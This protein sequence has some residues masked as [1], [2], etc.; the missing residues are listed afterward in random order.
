MRA[1]YS[2]LRAFRRV[3][4]A[5]AA[6]A[7]E[8]AGAG[9]GTAGA[10]ASPPRGFIMDMTPLFD[11]QTGRIQAIAPGCRAVTG[12]IESQPF[13]W[14]RELGMV[15][16][17][18]PP[19]FYGMGLYLSDDGRTVAGFLRKREEESPPPGYGQTWASPG[20]LWRHGEET[21]L[22][23]RHG[24]ID[25]DWYG[26]SADGRVAVGK[27][28]EPVPGAPAPDASGEELERFAQTPQG[29]QAM[30]RGYIQN[31]PLWFR[32][33]GA[34]FRELEDFRQKIPLLGRI[35]SRDG[36]TIMTFREPNSLVRDLETGEERLLTFGGA[37][38][39]G[40]PDEERTILRPGDPRNPLSRWGRDRILQIGRLVTDE[41]M[42]AQ[43]NILSPQSPMFHHWHV[44]EI[45]YGVPSFDA[46]HVLCYVTLDQY[47]PQSGTALSQRRL[48]LLAR[49]D[50]RGGA[51]PID[52]EK[53]G[54]LFLGDISDNGR[55]I[56]YQQDREMRV[57]DE[58]IQPPHR[59]RGS[60]TLREYLASF[61]LALP[62]GRRITDALMSPDGRCF[63]GRLDAEE[64]DRRFPYREFLAC[65]GEGI[66]PPH[67]APPSPR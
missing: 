49:L 24:L 10:A 19:T 35:L 57:W 37:V 21:H 55:I 14:S 12:I 30:S 15:R 36:K 2:V 20:F 54:S 27:G 1:L 45:S 63:F 46:R 43:K 58:D 26:L 40:L 47:L 67:W 64:E 13:V 52:D 29:R 59:L 39:D 11:E 60:W 6:E 18:P 33:N 8:A 16:I 9:A 17:P 56:L 44:R 23:S 65:T 34:S 66:E 4:S 51:V 28:M 41:D 22:M 32:L 53:Q 50:D 48:R 61:G 3:P 31:R 42:A 7:T 38:A 5:P 25:V 62:P